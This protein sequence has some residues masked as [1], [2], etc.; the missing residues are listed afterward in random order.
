MFA[1]LLFRYVWEDASAAKHCILSSISVLIVCL[2]DWE[3]LFIAP[4]DERVYLCLCLCVCM[5]SLCVQ[6]CRLCL[7]G[8]VSALAIGSRLRLK[9]LKLGACHEMQTLHFDCQPETINQSLVPL[10]LSF[11]AVS[12]QLLLCLSPATAAV[13]VFI[14]YAFCPEIGDNKHIVVRKQWLC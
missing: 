4:H 12:L 3:P 8:S 14:C 6:L 9:H 13:V 5:W 11:C 10:L 2:H 7:F 1:I